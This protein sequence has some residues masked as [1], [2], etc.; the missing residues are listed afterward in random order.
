MTGN[1]ITSPDRPFTG[2]RSAASAD[3]AIRSLLVLLVFFALSELVLL[4]TISRIGIHI[5]K[6][7]LVLA[8]YE[9]LTG[10]GS[11]AFNLASVL[12]VLTLGL[13]VYRHLLSHGRSRPAWLAAIVLSL[14]LALGVALPFIENS[15]VPRLLF[16]LLSVTAMIALAAPYCLNK[17][18]PGLRRC[19]LALVLIAY[20]CAQYQTLA[21]ASYGL[22]GL[23]SVPRSTVPALAIGEGLIAISA[24]TVFLGWGRGGLAIWHLVPSTLVTVLLLGAF[25]S[26]AATVAILALWMEG[27]T[28]YLPLAVYLLALWLYLLTI[29]VRLSFHRDLFVG[30]GL[31]LLLVAG[32][33]LDTTYQ[34]ILAIL[35]LLLIVSSHIL[36]IPAAE[37]KDH[38]E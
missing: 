22:L 12:A 3:A 33:S 10:F 5:P 7:G 24:I 20:L 18:K 31:V 1:A 35:S 38:F 6:E 29:I 21:Q 14:V 15:G 19:A 2:D 11:F 34:Y 32:Y 25:R 27:L 30:I 37:N 28:L 8:A 13:V 26:N 4:R 17:E 16:S 23:H 36:D 9:T